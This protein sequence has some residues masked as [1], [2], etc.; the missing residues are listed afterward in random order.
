MEN[1]DLNALY[2]F[3]DGYGYR[4]SRIEKVNEKS[5]RMEQ[6]RKINKEDFKHTYKLTEDEVKIFN[7]ELIKKLSDSTYGIKK[8]ISSICN[9]KDS[10]KDSELVCVNTIK[11]QGTLDELNNLLEKEI[12]AF[13][14]NNMKLNFDNYSERLNEVK[15]A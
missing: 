6:G 5:I 3:N 10:L 7:R 2:L 15:E 1:Y 8:M 14:I 4:I 13:K 9:L 11:L 12:E